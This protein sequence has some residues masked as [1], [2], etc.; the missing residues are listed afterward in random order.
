MFEECA[1]EIQSPI[2]SMNDSAPSLTAQVPY[3]SFACDIG[4][5]MIGIEDVCG[6]DLNASFE[7]PLN[8][9]LPYRSVDRSRPRFLAR[10]AD[11][12]AVRN[13][14]LRGDAVLLIV[15]V[16]KTCGMPYEPSEVAHEQ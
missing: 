14:A 15:C 16:K 3:C 12:I 1:S 10:L 8:D 6:H 13:V 7:Q 9:L 2:S 5:G 4:S 11:Q